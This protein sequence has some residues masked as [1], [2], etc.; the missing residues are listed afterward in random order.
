MVSKS[1]VGLFVIIDV[2]GD[3]NPE[4][5][6]QESMPHT[7]GIPRNDQGDHSRYHEDGNATHLRCLCGIPK[8]ADDG[9]CEEAGGIAGV[10]NANIHDNTAVD[11]P[12]GEDA[13]PSWAV[14]AVHF[15]VC[16]VGTQASDEQFSL[17]LVQECGRLRPVWNKPLRPDG[18]AACYDA[19]AVGPS[20]QIPESKGVSRT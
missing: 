4:Y 6:E 10:D 1:E 19:F 17:V 11:F 20:A 5:T 12:V 16:H 2:P 18:Y 9:R 8:I 13:F 15:C 3:A 14:E 7:I